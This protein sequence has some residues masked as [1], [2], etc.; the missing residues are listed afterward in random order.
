MHNRREVGEPRKKNSYGHSQMIGKQTT[1]KLLHN[2]SLSAPDTLCNTLFAF[3]NRG[4][5]DTLV[6]RRAARC[7]LQGQQLN[8]LGVVEKTLQRHRL[9]VS[10][11]MRAHWNSE[12][13]IALAYL[14]EV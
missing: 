9:S 3:H 5:H 7:L 1:S 12:V 4:G 6:H 10:W 14:A 2:E 8:V 13:T 11:L